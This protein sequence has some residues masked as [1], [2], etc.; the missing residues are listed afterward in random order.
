MRSVNYFLIKHNTVYYRFKGYQR[1]PGTFL[2]F[3]HPPVIETY[4][5]LKNILDV[6]YSVRKL[7]VEQRDPQKQQQK[8][9][10]LACAILQTP[11]AIKQQYHER[12]LRGRGNN[13]ENSLHLQIHSNSPVT[14]IWRCSW[15]S[16][17]A[18]VDLLN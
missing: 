10:V 8:N 5:V 13:I 1:L 17:A 14:S 11:S 7:S 16:P 18:Y 4:L 3:Q 6:G 2:S 15:C 9:V 12:L